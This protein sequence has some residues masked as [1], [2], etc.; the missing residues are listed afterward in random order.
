LTLS[1]VISARPVRLR[2]LLEP[3][4]ANAKHTWGEALVSSSFAPR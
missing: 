3:M 4:S 2:K 1:R